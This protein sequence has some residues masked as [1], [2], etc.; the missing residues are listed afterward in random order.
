MIQINYNILVS[1]PSYIK[2]RD[3]Y[4]HPNKASACC[5]HLLCWSSSRRITSQTNRI[6]SNANVHIKNKERQAPRI[7]EG[8]CVKYEQKT[9]PFLF[10]YC[11]WHAEM[12]EWSQTLIS[13]NNWMSIKDG[14]KKKRRAATGDCRRR[15]AASITF[16]IDGEN[17]LVLEPAS[18]FLAHSV[19]SWSW[20][21]GLQH[22]GS[23]PF[24]A[25]AS[26]LLLLENDRHTSNFLFDENETH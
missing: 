22:V 3:T 7:A 24:C 21:N 10:I 19:T 11:W 2:N 26:F 14:N 20:W 25:T 1:S 18:P 15:W 16:S 5:P 23:F 9:N 17:S 8:C 4:F 12:N 6:S 13:N